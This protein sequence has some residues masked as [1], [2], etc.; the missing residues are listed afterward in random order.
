[1]YKIISLLFILN[2]TYCCNKPNVHSNKINDSK[3]SKLIVVDSTTFINLT[4]SVLSTNCFLKNS[5][6]RKILNLSFPNLQVYNRNVWA[7]S[8]LEYS[9]IYDEEDLKKLY[10]GLW[11]MYNKDSFLL[12]VQNENIPPR[13]FKKSTDLINI[14]SY[15]GG[16]EGPSDIVWL[17]DYND[18]VLS[19]ISEICNENE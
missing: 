11:L 13:V 17:F 6:K 4:E 5:T 7:V 2:L 3:I 19:S 10:G 1:M 12:L 8:L 9:Y 14:N 18:G 15:L 16:T